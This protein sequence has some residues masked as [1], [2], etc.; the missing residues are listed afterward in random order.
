MATHHR[1]QSLSRGKSHHS[2]ASGPASPWVGY[3]DGVM[4]MS[5]IYEDHDHSCQSTNEMRFVCE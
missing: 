1:S 3:R 5:T 2:V 4:G